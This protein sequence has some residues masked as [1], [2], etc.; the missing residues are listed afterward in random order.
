MVGPQ[1]PGSL[2]M[3]APEQQVAPKLGPNEVAPGHEIS[4][5]SMEDR[6]LNGKYRIEFDG[7][8]KLPYNVTITTGRMDLGELRDRIVSAYRSYFR[9]PPTIAVSISDRKF[10]V[11]TRGLVEKPGQHLVKPGTS[12]DEIIATSGGLQKTGN[13]RYVRIEQGSASSSVKLSDYYAGAAK[14]LVPA[15]VGGDV[16][17]FLSD[18]G[19]TDIAG[20][21]SAYLQILGEVK[22]PGEYR[23]RKDADFYFYLAKAGGPTERANLQR[24]ELIRGGMYRRSTTD[25]DLDEP[26]ALPPLA[27]GD[28]IIVHPDKTTRTE[29]AISTISGIT[30]ILN[31][32][33]L[34]IILLVR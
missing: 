22:N 29:K 10:W 31:S 34:G 25:F 28:L 2:G 30:A 11:E 32:I 12:L 3:R 17:S 23:F 19:D 26:R 6:A 13:A 14:N 16:I 20:P 5:S 1:P 21:D 7:Q 24:I 27:A 18:L 15:W 33:L 9:T 8:L 4:L